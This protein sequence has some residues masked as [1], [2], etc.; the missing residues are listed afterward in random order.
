MTRP[1]TSN[2]ARG[3]TLIE[4]TLALVLSGLVLA[5]CL[6]VF[7]ALRNAERVF[8]TRFERTNE[9]SIA[10]T[11]LSRAMLSLQMK[12]ADTST[13]VRAGSEEDQAD[14]EEVTERDRLILETDYTVEPDSSGWQPQRL[15]VVCATPPVPPG[16]ASNAAEWYTAQSKEESLDFSALDGSQGITRGV[17]ELRPSGEREYIMAQL[18][19][20]N[21][22]IESMNENLP[23]QSQLQEP[24]IPSWTLWWRP[25]LTYESEQL[26]EG[27]GPLPDTVGTEDEIRE[28]L[29]G[30]VPLLREIERCVWE[31]YK[32][33]EF[34]TEHAG[35]EMD[36]L[37]AYV[38]FEVILTNQQYASWM[39]EVDWVLGDDPLDVATAASSSETDTVD[40]GDVNTNTGNTN[41]GGGGGTGGR[42]GNGNNNGNTGPGGNRFDFSDDS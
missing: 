37:P 22:G 20:S 29:S 11:S 31:F 6:S 23:E 24:E 36:D 33:D 4:V 40:T 34:I 15:E 16:L 5:G 27:Y 10:H 42:P 32:E 28:R 39:F 41:G 26:L 2:R 18:G 19:L 3:F 1:R 38:Q 7:I 12:E 14:D 17:F 21:S 13:V 25:I 8:A 30:A 9:L 35:L